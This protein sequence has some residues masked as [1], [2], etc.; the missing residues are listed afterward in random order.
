MADLSSHTNYTGKYSGL[1]DNLWVTLVIAGACLI[2]YE[3]EAHIP[4]RRGRQGT[5]ERLPVR[6]FWTLRR[7]WGEWP[8]GKRRLSREQ[9]GLS[10]DEMVREKGVSLNDKSVQEEKARKRLG[11]REGWE[12]G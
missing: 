12:F 4:R 10:A 6:V 5:F 8:S 7:L 1:L 11:S 9:G 2:G 3:I